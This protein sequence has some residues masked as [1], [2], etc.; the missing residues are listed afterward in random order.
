LPQVINGLVQ[1]VLHLMGGDADC[2]PSVWPSL[3]SEMR[4]PAAA[5]TR[6]LAPVSGSNLND[7]VVVVEPTSISFNLPMRIG[8]R[9]ARTS[10]PPPAAV[11]SDRR[12]G[13]RARARRIPSPGLYPPGAP[14]SAFSIASEN[15]RRSSAASITGPLTPA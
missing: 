14:P 12:P 10:A 11:R 8:A 2:S 6:T 5:A 15:R 13:G 3:P 9:W 1:L 7:A 4:P